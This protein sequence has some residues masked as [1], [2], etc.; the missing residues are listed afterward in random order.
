VDY[1]LRLLAKVIWNNSMLS[2]IV[3]CSIASNKISS[4]TSL[5]RIFL[6]YRGDKVCQ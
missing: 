6:L 5:S 4:L 2:D 1:R 3:T